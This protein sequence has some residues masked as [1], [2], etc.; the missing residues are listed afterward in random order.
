MSAANRNDI[1][2]VRER[3][4]TTREAATFLKVSEASI[5]RWT[6]SGLLPASRVGRRRARRLRE[7]DLRT[8]MEAGPAPSTGGADATPPS[9]MVIQDVVVPLGSHLA[10][11]YTTDAGRLRLGLPFLRDGLL[12]GQ[13]VMLLRATPD[14][15]EQYFAALRN[16]GLD[17]EQAIE[18]GLLLLDPEI[19]GPASNQVARFE[20][21]LVAASRR[22][23]GPIRILAEVLADV[24]TVGSV[25]EYLVVEEKVDALF[26][27]FPVVTLCA[28][29]V[30]AFDAVSVI[31]ALKLHPDMFGPHIG[32]WLN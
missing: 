23:P 3:L 30:R 31:E 8:F 18:A 21:L 11:F 7:E 22:R 12:A 2:V 5:R 26:K 6:D 28:Y 19:S 17:T 4:L 32:Y 9:M 16:E 27:R 13:S 29:D 15:R 25:A 20:Q 1:P 10:A 14:V 24:Q